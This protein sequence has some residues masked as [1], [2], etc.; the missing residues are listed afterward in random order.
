MS[1]LLV[2]IFALIFF[3]FLMIIGIPIGVAFFVAGVAGII[4]IRGLTSGLHSLGAAPY[5]WTGMDALLPI[6]LFVL[7][8][9]FAFYSGISSDLY[10]A[11]NKWIGRLPGGIALA[12]TLACTGFAACSGDS[13]SGAATMGSIAYPEMERLKYSKRLS[14]ACI[15]AGGTLGVLIPPSIG[16]V[17]YGFLT[18]TSIAK[19]FMAGILP[20]LLLSGL[21]CL[22][23]YIMCKRNPRLGPPSAVSYSWKEKIVSL[24]GVWSMSILILVILGG[25]YLGI[26]TPSEAGAIGAFGA[27]LITLVKRKMTLSNLKSVFKDALKITCILFTILIGA[28]VFNQLMAV[29]GFVTRF[30]ELVAA[31]PVSPYGILAF[32][33]L[34]YI[35]LGMFMDVGAMTILTVPTVVPILVNLGFDPIWFGVLVVIMG[36]IG[37]ITPPVGLNV[38]IVHG[39]TRVPMQDIFIGTLPFCCAM[40]LCIIVIIVFPQIALFLP[41]KM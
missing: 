3:V 18:Q 8:G 30:G 15:A 1:P 9:F 14:T 4:C 20:G 2:G 12:T 5:A 31:L 10:A 6:P 22:M 13:M 33:L 21:F 17:L 23:I 39:V 11:A 32:I 36:E 25:L 16:F 38:Y 29:S 27:F 35:P 19:L 7:M 40:L 24:R 28:M 37:L 34:L 26:F 41:G